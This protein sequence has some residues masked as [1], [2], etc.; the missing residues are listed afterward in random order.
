MDVLGRFLASQQL[1]HHNLFACL[2]TDPRLTISST[3][4]RTCRMTSLQ[5]LYEA[6]VQQVPRW[7]KMS[8]AYLRPKPAQLA[9]WE[10]LALCPHLS[11]CNSAT[12]KYITANTHGGFLHTAIQC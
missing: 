12:Y 3:A 8:L 4:G 6:A 5:Q 2:A 1:V 9:M 7:G 11:I 10:T